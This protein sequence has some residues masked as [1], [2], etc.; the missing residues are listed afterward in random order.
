MWK[1]VLREDE[2][3]LVLAILEIQPVILLF[4]GYPHV[5]HIFK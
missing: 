3:V 2:N 5:S 4:Q 1:N